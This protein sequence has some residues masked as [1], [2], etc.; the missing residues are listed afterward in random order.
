MALDKAITCVLVVVFVFVIVYFYHIFKYG[1]R[2]NTPWAIKIYWENVQKFNH[3]KV[4][5]HSH[6]RKMQF[7]SVPMAISLELFF[8]SRTKQHFG[9]A[10]N[11]PDINRLVTRTKIYLG[12]FDVQN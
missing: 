10:K 9:H 6:R 8:T 5:L 2:K 3:I 12:K 4:Q 11:N 1:N 7:I